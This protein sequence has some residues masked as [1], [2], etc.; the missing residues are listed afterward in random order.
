MLAAA[1]TADVIVINVLFHLLL[2]PAVYGTLDLD[3]VLCHIVLDELICTE[4][5]FTA[6]AVHQ[7]VREAANMTGSNPGHRVHQ[8][9]GVKTYIVL[10][11][12]HKFL[13]PCCLDVVLELKAERTVFTGLCKTA[14]NLRAGVYEAAALAECY[15]LFHCFFAVFHVKFSFWHSWLLH[16]VFALHRKKCLT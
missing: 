12:L 9:R 5:L 1:R 14:L 2:G 4:T 15:D 7:R 3:V 8:D 11:L 13:A 10:A 16:A 6:L